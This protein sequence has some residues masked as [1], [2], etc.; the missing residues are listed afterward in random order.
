MAFSPTL[1]DKVAIRTEHQSATDIAIQIL[2]E[3]RPDIYQSHPRAQL[4]K[5]ASGE[6]LK[7]LQSELERANEELS[8]YRCPYCGA[9]VEER[10][11]A[12]TEGY[13]DH[14][15]LHEIFACGYHAFDGV[16]E[17]PCP[18]DSRFPTFQ[19]YELQFHE[20]L[21]D[22]TTPWSCFALSKTEM[23]RKLS[24][25]VAYGRTKNDAETHLR[26]KYDRLAKKYA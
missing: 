9:P 8:E 16:V 15:G 23:A 17:S 10:G 13:P 20:N 19:D 5:L 22:S 1:A 2:R 24:L 12:P 26:E 6:A 11:G 14:Y 21:D 7:E 25:G 3:V 4:E 18:S